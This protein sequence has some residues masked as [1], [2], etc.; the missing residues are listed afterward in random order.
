MFRVI[1]V[2]C[3]LRFAWVR[4]G[5]TTKPT[6]PPRKPWPHL[7]HQGKRWKYLFFP[8]RMS[9]FSFQ[10]SP[11]TA[12]PA[13]GQQTTSWQHSQQAQISK[14]WSAVRDFLTHLHQ[15]EAVPRLLED[16][17]ALSIVALGVQATKLAGVTTDKI[18][19]INVQMPHLRPKVSI[20]S[21][22]NSESSLFELILCLTGKFQMEKVPHVL[23]RTIMVM[24]QLL[25]QNPEGV[26]P[27]VF[28][29]VVK[30]IS[31]LWD[32]VTDN[33][34]RYHLPILGLFNPSAIS[35]LFKSTSQRKLYR[36][37]VMPLKEYIIWLTNINLL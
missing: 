30:T 5:P 16:T 23:L 27:A 1:S 11:S 10:R 26:T 20:S 28:E 9:F 15:L 29:K 2:F 14:Y 35:I 21:V 32:L 37:S 3:E 8:G 17:Q 36:V 33:P 13:R 24:T 22:L 25:S 4:S 18:V 19:T 6:N 34:D 31:V 7:Q 12:I